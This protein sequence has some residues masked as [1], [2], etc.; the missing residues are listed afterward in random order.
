ML[1]LETRILGRKCRN[2]LSIV[3]ELTLQ[4]ELQHFVTKK[5][6]FLQKSKNTTTKH[7]LKHKNPCR[8]RKSNAGRLA[9]QSDALPLYQWCN[10]TRIYDNKVYLLQ[11][12][13]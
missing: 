3:N 6:F 2:M 8:S 1:Y 5:C 4:K 12:L 9:P 7:K 11:P 10:G 13:G